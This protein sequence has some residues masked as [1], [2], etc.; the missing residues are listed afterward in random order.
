MTKTEVFNII[1]NLKEA[2]PQQVRDIYYTVNGQC[3]FTQSTLRSDHITKYLRDLAKEGMLTK[4]R[5]RSRRG[6]AVI[7]CLASTAGE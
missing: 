3:V 6:G 2:T 4:K 7:Y 1:K 5:D